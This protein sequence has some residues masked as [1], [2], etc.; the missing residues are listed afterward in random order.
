MY[1]F[2]GFISTKKVI[3]GQFGAP[4]SHKY[5][6]AMLGLDQEMPGQKY[7]SNQAI[8]VLCMQSRAA[9]CVP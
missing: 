7:M 9:L 5:N 6:L 8:Q 3:V 1:L 4:N 2:V